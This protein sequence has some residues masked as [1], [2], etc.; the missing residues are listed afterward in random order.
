MG[1]PSSTNTGRCSILVYGPWTQP[2]C[3]WD[4]PC[5][6]Q[7]DGQHYTCPETRSEPVRALLHVQP[8]LPEPLRKCDMQ[9][10]FCPATHRTM[11]SGRDKKRKEKK[12]LP[13]HRRKDRPG[14][15][16]ERHSAPRRGPSPS[17]HTPSLARYEIPGITRLALRPVLASNTP[18]VLF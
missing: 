3:S 2:R 12:Q 15:R 10:Q 16:P 13:K 1:T 8:D 11:M 7:N 9:L 5:S 4:A 14:L 18:F 6:V 17:T